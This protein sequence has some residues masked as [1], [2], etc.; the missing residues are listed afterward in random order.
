MKNILFGLILIFV[1][2]KAGNDSPIAAKT[3]EKVYKDFD[4]LLGDWQKLNNNPGTQTF[5]SW[6]KINAE[7]YQGQSYTMVGQQEIWRESV[8]LSKD[9][10]AW[11]YVVT[12]KGQTEGVTFK[13]TMKE[14]GKFSCENPNNEFPTKIV[15]QRAGDKIHAKITGGGKEI[16]F[17]F[18]KMTDKK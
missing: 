13:L 9:S 18:E 16:P 14:N 15:Y 8:V 7:K 2:C 10:T 4:W 3:E 6:E 17:D 5:E 11:N 1:A 12:Q